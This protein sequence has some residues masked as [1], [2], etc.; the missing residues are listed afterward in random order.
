MIT[1]WEAAVVLST[2]CLVLMV[3]RERRGESSSV[4]FAAG[5]ASAVVALV[6][7]LGMQ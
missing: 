3:W 2:A 6:I 5:L 7:G 4:Y 1:A